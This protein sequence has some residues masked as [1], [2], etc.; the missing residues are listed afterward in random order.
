[1]HYLYCV[2]ANKNAIKRRKIMRKRV[3]I[4]VLAIAVAMMAPAANATLTMSIDYTA[5]VINQIS[6]ITI[7]TDAAVTTTWGVYLD[8][9][10]VYP[11]NARLQTATILPAAGSSGAVTSGG[12]PTSGNNYASGG[13]GRTAGS[14]STVQFVG[15]TA[16]TYTIDLYQPGPVTPPGTQIATANIVVTPEPATIALLG[17]GGLFML[18]RRR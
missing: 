17:L 15:L 4:L 9:I 11:T 7:I 2:A 13:G 14:L 1:V 12:T 5:R 18:R 3:F 16:G 6:V 10:S 8:P